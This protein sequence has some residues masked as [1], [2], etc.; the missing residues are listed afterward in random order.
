[1]KY[2]E[3]HFDTIDSTNLYLK[4]NY[5]SL[6]DFLIVSSD[7]Q[8]LGRGRNERIWKSNKGE[9]LLFS[10]LLKRQDIISQG[11]FLSLV[12]AV[13]VSEILIKH[14]FKGVSIKWP[15][16]IYI[17]G[18]KAVGILLEGQ[19]KEYLV[20][21]IGVNV[22]QEDFEDGEYRIRPTSL[23]LESGEKIDINSFKKEIYEKLVS[24]I[25]NVNLLKQ[26]FLLFYKEHDYLF[27]KDIRFYLN[28]ELNKG[29][30]LGV[31]DDFALLVK[32]E[33]KLIH[34]SS[35]EVSII[36]DK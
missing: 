24:N 18:K 11:G 9:N 6:D 16:D 1:M 7:Y 15:N 8:S 34:L 31:D 28:G 14:G 19:I 12:A 5:Q 20:I 36:F 23:F 27:D 30:V 10:L 32:E 22:N 29:K 26:D 17:D 13:S 3:I 35:G 25:D 33:E 21:G 4:E 2:K